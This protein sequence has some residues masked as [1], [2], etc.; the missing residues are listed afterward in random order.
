MNDG[1]S[2]PSADTALDRTRVTDVTAV[3]EARLTAADVLVLTLSLGVGVG[4]LHAA[5]AEL[6]AR[7]VRTFGW[8]GRGLIWM[9][10]IGYLLFLGGPAVI[11]ALLAARQS[12]WASWRSAGIV[13]GFIAALSLGLLLPRVHWGAIALLALGV[14]VWSGAQLSARPARWR[15]RLRVSALVLPVLSGLGAL[16]NL[17]ARGRPSASTSAADS[18]PNVLIIILD[19]V[20]ASS[21]GLYGYGRAT[22]PSIDSL[23][24]TSVVFDRAM[25]PAPWTLPS[26]ASMFTGQLPEVLST[27]W[28]RPLDAT[29]PTIDE[30]F[31]GQGYATGGFV[32]NPFYTSMESGLNR[33]FDV[34]RDADVSLSQLV[35]STTLGQTPLVNDLVWARSPRQVVR[36][37]RSFN[38]TVPS[39]P[40]SDRR[41]AAEV[42]PEFL[43]WQSTLG[44][45]PFFAFVNLFDAHDPYDPPDDWREKFSP[46][47]DKQ[48]LYDAGIA[49][50]DHVLD[51]A[52]VVL[53]QRGVIDRTVVVVS[54]DHGEQFGEH[55]LSNHGNSLY[56]PLLHV[57]LILRYPPRFPAG[58]HVGAVVTTRDLAVTLLELAEL[59]N[60]GRLPGRSLLLAR[61]SSGVTSGSDVIAQTEALDNTN[62]PGP[63][64]GY[65]L[66][67]ILSDS[68]HLIR[69]G[70]G[71][72]ELYAHRSDPEEEHS[73]A[74]VAPWCESARMLDAQLRAVTKRPAAPPYPPLGCARPSKMFSPVVDSR[75]PQER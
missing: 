2:A 22:T 3:A 43:E 29:Y 27:S 41:L 26:H 31:R 13:L 59:P 48:A 16:G 9:A 54:S 19:T 44:G 10:P 66:S 36:A 4:L 39:E 40:H 1:D 57:P 47:P 42:I 14:A 50:M 23:A 68:L 65:D 7:L 56:L 51:S 58:R 5:D 8:Q 72:F 20:R 64:S 75:S 38:L 61:D 74:S 49:Y 17:A 60:A 6:H 11:L 24:R 37:L 53:R 63:A 55:G 45:R 69:S 12:R 25:A 28:R 67:A 21:M 30:S 15:A 62:V 71:S 35:W 18:A 46:H 32:A 70:N 34:Y 52:F 33:G 73:L